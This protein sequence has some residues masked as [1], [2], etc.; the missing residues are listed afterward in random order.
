MHPI[1]KEIQAVF[2][3]RL[4]IRVSGILIENE[5]VLMV[6][7]NHIGTEGYL[8][9]APGGGL[10]YAESAHEG[11]QREFRE[12]TGLEIFIQRFLFVNEY[13]EPPLHAIELFFEV[14]QVAGT[15]QKGADPEMPQDAQMIQEVRFLSIEEIQ[16]ENLSNL[17][18]V[19]RNIP[20]IS[21]ILKK[22]GYYYSNN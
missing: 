15:L 14:K 12:E 17:H 21:F 7:H 16:Q 18:Q 22:K 9:A 13:L 1:K 3:N 19:F 2:G 5:Q 10:K 6:K 11:L 20:K 4:R 8:W